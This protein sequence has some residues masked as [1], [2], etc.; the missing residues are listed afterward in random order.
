MDRW[1]TE[2]RTD[3]DRLEQQHLLRRLEGAAST[4]VRHGNEQLVNLASNDYLGLTQLP[5]LKQAAIDAIKAGKNQYTQT[6]GIPDLIN[7]LKAKV[8]IGRAHV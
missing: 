3:L 5:R 2:L 8:Q 6:Q 1:L 7:P 4:G